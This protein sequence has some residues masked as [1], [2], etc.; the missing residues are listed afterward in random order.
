M[1][2]VVYPNIQACSPE[3]LSPD[4]L[5]LIETA[6]TQESAMKLKLAIVGLIML[7]N[8]ACVTTTNSYS[9]DI[10]YRDGS[11]YSPAD[12]QYGDYYY[13]PEPEY[14]YYGYDYGFGSGFYGNP[15]YSHHDAYRCRFSYRYDRYCD[16]GWGSF[17]L[18]FGGLSLIF[19]NSGYYDYGYGYGYGYPYYGYYNPYHGHHSPRPS[20][21]PIPVRK[22]IRPAIRNPDNSVSNRPSV[23]VRGEPTRMPT[24]PG[25]LEP[26]TQEPVIE[27]DSRRDLNP[28][29]RTR[30]PRQDRR[31]ETWRDR[32]DSD[33][34]QNDGI[35]IDNGSPRSRPKPLPVI[36]SDRDGQTYD[37]PVRRQQRPQPY[38]VN[39][40]AG[41]TAGPMIQPRVVPERVQRPERP[42]VERTERVERVERSEPIIRQESRDRSKDER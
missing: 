22:P 31:P 40:D 21:D 15:W 27:P 17:S 14:D 42:R 28:Y 41:P 1:R 10:V 18:N 4:S 16:N 11:Y 9:R 5:G 2:Y 34:D 20:N 30:E 7:G 3:K 8:T 25:V 32:N 29:T 35:E 12:D 6:L 39:T 38:P 33:R 23:R 37:R 26:D 19:G 24:K 13:E 36:E